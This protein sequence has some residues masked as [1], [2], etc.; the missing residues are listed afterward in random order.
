MQTNTS[1]ATDAKQR[2]TLVAERALLDAIEA[3]KQR[4][5][6]QKGLRVTLSQAA[7][8]LLRLGLEVAA[9]S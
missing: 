2:F 6:E 3:Y 8:G 9:T 5:E 7:A 4:I 1:E